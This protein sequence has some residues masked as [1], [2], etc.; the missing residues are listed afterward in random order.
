MTRKM[1]N[2]IKPSQ[3]ITVDGDKWTIKTVST[4]KSSEI[5]FVLGEEFDEN[6]IDGRKAKVTA[7]SVKIRFTLQYT[8]YMYIV[9]LNDNPV[10]HNY[11]PPPPPRHTQSR[12][13]T[14][15]FSIKRASKDEYFALV[16]LG[17]SNMASMQLPLIHKIH[18]NMSILKRS[19]KIRVK[20]L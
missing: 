14:Y 19:Y 12:N 18:H 15:K 1:G 17:A 4:F 2:T 3:I 13:N 16:Q 5:N 11:P 8:V 6:T 20:L 7:L 9:F 10:M